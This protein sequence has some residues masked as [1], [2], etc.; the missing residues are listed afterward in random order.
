MER[1]WLELDACVCARACSSL[2]SVCVGMMRFMFRDYVYPISTF[3]FCTEEIQCE[4][5][6]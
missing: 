1:A 6:H 4:M 2:A 3:R 5:R